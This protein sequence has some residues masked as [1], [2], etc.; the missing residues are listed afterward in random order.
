M[1]DYETRSYIAWHR[2]MLLVMVAFLFVLE[3]RQL[4]LKKNDVGELRPV[5]TTPQALDLIL[6]AFSKD[7]AIIKKAL[8]IVEYHMK[9]YTKSYQSF[10]RKRKRLHSC[11]A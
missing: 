2:H 5:L 4:F 3:V 7:I 1:S 9:T 10:S 8:Q 6:A 11:A